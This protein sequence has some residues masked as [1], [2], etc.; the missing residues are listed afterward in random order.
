MATVDAA[1]RIKMRILEETSASRAELNALVH[2]AAD[3]NQPDAKTM[4]YFIGQG[5]VAW[6]S[7]RPTTRGY[8]IALIWADPGFGN[9][10]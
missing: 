3:N 6:D 7:R 1:Q 10:K 5:M 2:L 4:D 8:Q 9:L